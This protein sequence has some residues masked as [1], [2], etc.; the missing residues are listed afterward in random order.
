MQEGHKLGQDNSTNEI[1]QSKY[2]LTNQLS[3]FQKKSIE[4]SIERK[5]IFEVKMSQ[6]KQHNDQN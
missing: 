2:F 3:F 4:E 5:I 6:S 1:D